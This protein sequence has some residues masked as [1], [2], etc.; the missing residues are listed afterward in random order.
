MNA[1][2]RPTPEEPARRRPTPTLSDVTPHEASQAD[3]DRAPFQGEGHRTVHARLRIHDVIRAARTR[4]LR[5]MRAH[6]LLSTHRG[7]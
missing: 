6:G 7:R 5:V 2:T 3:L 4:V 1:A